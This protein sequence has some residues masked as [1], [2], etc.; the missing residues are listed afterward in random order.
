MFLKNVFSHVILIELTKHVTY[1]LISYS[2]NTCQFNILNYIIF[3]Y[4]NLE[5]FE[6]Q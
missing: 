1:V 2:K 6:S 3:F 4:P 5:G